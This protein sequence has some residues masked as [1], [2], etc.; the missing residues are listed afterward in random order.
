VCPACQQCARAALAGRVLAREPDTP[1][2]HQ[3]PGGPV[4]QAG[5][6]DQSIPPA[7]FRWPPAAGAGR[8][9]QETPW[10]HL[11]GALA[12]DRDG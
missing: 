5:G 6:A 8:H 7:A 4:R 3:A 9:H 12:G 1:G 2:D 11:P 10:P